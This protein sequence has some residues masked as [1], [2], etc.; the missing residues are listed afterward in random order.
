MKLDGV[1]DFVHCDLN[2]NGMNR[3]AIAY[4]GEVFESTMQE[5]I[6]FQKN[7]SELYAKL[8]RFC[9]DN[10]IIVEST[11]FGTYATTIRIQK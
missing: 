5:R 11:N 1:L 3:N 9:A 10:G 6:V 2:N 4:D 7:H 8:L